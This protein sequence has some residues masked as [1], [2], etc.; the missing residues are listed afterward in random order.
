MLLHWRLNQ[1]RVADNLCALEL[2]KGANLKFIIHVVLYNTRYW[3]IT[4]VCT[5]P[6][7]PHFESSSRSKDDGSKISTHFNNW[8]LPY[9]LWGYQKITGICITFSLEQ[10]ISIM[11]STSRLSSKENVN[12]TLLLFNR[13]AYRSHEIENTA[14][15]HAHCTLH[16]AEGGVSPA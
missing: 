3:Y 5:V 2:V 14:E 6:A 10:N 1:Q 13:G 12:M 7:Q 15:V 8:R 9:L 4:Y 16:A 11:S